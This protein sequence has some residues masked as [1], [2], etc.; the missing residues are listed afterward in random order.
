MIHF[1]P[2][3]ASDL[4]G[5]NDLALT[6][7]G[8]WGYSHD[9]LEAWRKDI[10]TDPETIANWPTVVAEEAREIRGFAQL[11]SDRDPW[12]LVSLWIDPKHMRRGLGR[13][14]LNQIRDIAASAGQTRIT[15]DADPNALAFYVACGAVVVDHQAAPIS[16]CPQRTRPQLILP[17]NAA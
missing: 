15:I 3:R 13:T 1:R 17:T 8:S 16:G 14:L 12:D 7:K 11:N 9:Q 5:M 6:S 10:E 2:A 4:P